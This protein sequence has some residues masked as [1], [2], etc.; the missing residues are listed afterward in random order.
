MDSIVD[1]IAKQI[2]AV[3]LLA[4]SD[5]TETVMTLRYGEKNFDVRLCAIMGWI[6]DSADRH[7]LTKESIAQV[8]TE[9]IGRELRLVEA[10]MPELP[11]TV[12]RAYDLISTPA[13]QEVYGGIIEILRNTREKWTEEQTKAVLTQFWAI[14]IEEYQKASNPG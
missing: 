6:R 14:S 12:R 11:T 10:S 8:V 13:G 4:A 2:I 9:L 3:D 1:S 5:S 7:N